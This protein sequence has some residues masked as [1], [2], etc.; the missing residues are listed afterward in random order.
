MVSF[1]SPNPVLLAYSSQEEHSI[2]EHCL[3]NSRISGGMLM[4]QSSGR[5]IR[6]SFRGLL[7]S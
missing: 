1:S 3:S 5:T 4:K 2:W 7:V 6:C